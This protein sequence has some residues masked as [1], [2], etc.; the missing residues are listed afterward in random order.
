MRYRTLGRTSLKASLVSL[1]IGWA[2]LLL[3]VAT[4]RLVAVALDYDTN[5]TTTIASYSESET[6]LG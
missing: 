3:E 1:M 6:V 2:K 4:R 5:L